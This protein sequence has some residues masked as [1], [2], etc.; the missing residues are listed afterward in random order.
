[1]SSGELVRHTVH[2]NARMIDVVDRFDMCQLR[3]LMQM[4]CINFMSNVWNEFIIQG[5][6]PE[7]SLMRCDAVDLVKHLLRNSDCDRLPMMEYHFAFTTA[8]RSRIELSKAN[9][10][11]IIRVILID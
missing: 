7:I 1:M 5:I 2:E 8:K 4:G 6:H 10:F 9:S 11:P 3:K